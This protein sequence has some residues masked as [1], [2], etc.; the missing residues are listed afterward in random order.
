M[1]IRH[2]GDIRCTA[3]RLSLYIMREKSLLLYT[4]DTGGAA[5]WRAYNAPD[6]V[7]SS[8]LPCA[9]LSMRPFLFLFPAREILHP[10]RMWLA[11]MVVI[12]TVRQ[13][14]EH[15]GRPKKKPSPIINRQGSLILNMFYMTI[16]LLYSIGMMSTCFVLCIHILGTDIRKI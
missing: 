6:L 8:S 4:G 11:K 15:R 5:L 16:Y 13:Q 10:K 12:H 3:S 7:T 14:Q 1:S 9:L 2:Q